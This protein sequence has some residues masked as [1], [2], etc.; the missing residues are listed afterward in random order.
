MATKTKLPP[1][2]R[3]LKGYDPE[4]FFDEMLTADSK[5]RPHYSRFHE[6]FQSLAQ[7]DFDLKRQS[8]DLAFLRQGVTF[9]VYGDAAGMEKIFPSTCCRASFR[10]RNGNIWSAA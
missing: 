2:A 6:L 4:K 5:T 7:N 3:M 9:N 8:V 10:R 1:R